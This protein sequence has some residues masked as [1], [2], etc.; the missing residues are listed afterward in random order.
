M[1]ALAELFRQCRL[2][3]GQGEQAVAEERHRHGVG[4]LLGAQSARRGIA[5]IGERLPAV[6]G[7][8]L[9]GVLEL[10]RGH[11]D[12]AAHL[13]GDRLGQFL[14]E[15][16]DGADRV[17]DVLTGGPVPAR[18]QLSQTTV[19]VAG[20]DRQPVELRLDTEAGDVVA[21]APGQ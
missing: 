19:G 11:Q 21:D 17:R 18:D 10:R 20:S 14:R 7:A 8:H 3:V 16:L 5:R 6:R 15:P 4:T 2:G 9:V 12:L 13:H 1:G